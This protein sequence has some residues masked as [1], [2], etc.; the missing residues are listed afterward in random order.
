MLNSQQQVSLQIQGSRQ[1]SAINA[2]PENVSFLR[3]TGSTKT[4][5]AKTLRPFY[6][7]YSYDLFSQAL[8]DRL[9]SQLC[10]PIEVSDNFPFRSFQ[11]AESIESFINI[12][13]CPATFIQGALPYI[14]ENTKDDFFN[15]II[16]ILRQASDMCYQKLEEI[17]CITCPHKPEGSMFV[18]VKLNF[19]CLDGIA[20]CVDFSY[21]LAKE[22]SV[23]VLPGITVGLRNWLRITFAV[24]LSSLSVGL[25]R[26]KSFCLRHARLKQ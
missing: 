19:S 26:L 1:R 11:I 17:D 13:S 6:K 22:E 21:K 9:N 14:L 16:D 5:E 2:T 25:D 12:T 3:R 8:K 23:I 4:E 15:K 20:D 10:N 18:M 24:D 7:S